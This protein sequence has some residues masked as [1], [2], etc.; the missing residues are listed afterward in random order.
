MFRMAIQKFPNSGSLRILY[1]F[2]LIENLGKKEEAL[3][4]LTY[5]ESLKPTFQEQFIIFRHKKLIEEF[6]SD[7][8][9]SN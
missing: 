6:N 4:E 9:Q 8:M 3:Q 1:A 7:S 5:A 2:F